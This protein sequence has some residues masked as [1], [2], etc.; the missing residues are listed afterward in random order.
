M[1]VV[2]A[3]LKLG[4]KYQIAS[5]R[6]EAVQRLIYEFPTT[7][8]ALD[9]TVDYSRI[10]D[11]KSVT[12]EFIGAIE[13]AHQYD[14]PQI[15]PWAFYGCCYYLTFKQ[16]CQPGSPQQPSLSREDV[17]TCMVGWQKLIEHQSRDTF[18]WLSAACSSEKSEVCNAT[19]KK[20]RRHFAPVAACKA[21]DPWGPWQQGL[22]LQCAAD[23]KVSHE[24]GRK[25]IWDKL[26]SF[27]GLPSWTQLLKE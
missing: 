19:R 24:S 27:F 1:A 11:P 4:T 17:Q 10:K 8:A 18:A 13:L 25:K 9:S 3:Y 26:P 16:I 6:E 2:T 7:L 20:L 22:C 14:V 12:V 15:L 21:L 23:V 5:V